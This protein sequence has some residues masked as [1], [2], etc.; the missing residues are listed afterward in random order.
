MLTNQ[1]D[2][3]TRTLY[4]IEGSLNGKEGVFEWIVDPNNG[5]THRNFIENGKVTGKPNN[6]PKNKKGK[7]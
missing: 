3:I 6:Y 7:R 1:K 2:G 5:V 4:Q